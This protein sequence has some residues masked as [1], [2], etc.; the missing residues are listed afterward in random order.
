MT[1]TVAQRL[2]WS[3]VEEERELALP[4]T[5]GERIT[6]P[7]FAGIEFVHVRAKSLL[8]HVPAAAGLP[9]EWTINVYR[10]VSMS[11]PTL[12][13]QVWR[14][15]EPGTPWSRGHPSATDG[16]APHGAHGTPVDARS[17]R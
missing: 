9:F 14:D 4:G 10:G 3:T 2:R 8:N 6:H 5:G 16:T 7:E 13:E 1:Q 17:G 12:D 15:T 11:I